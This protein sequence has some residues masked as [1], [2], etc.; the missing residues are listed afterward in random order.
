MIDRF[1]QLLKENVYSQR[2]L[3]NSVALVSTGANDYPFY[4]TAKKGSRDGLPAFT[5]GLVNQLA[6]DLQRINLL[7][8]KKVVA[9]TLPLLGCS[10]IHIIPPSTYQNCDE[11][12][13]KN[14]K[15]HNQLLQKAVEKLNTDDGN[16]STFV[17]LDLYN[18]M[19]SAIDQFRQNAAN[20]ACKNPLQP[21]CSKTVEY[22]CQRKDY[23]RVPSHLSFL[24]WH[25]L[26]TM[27][28]GM[29]FIHFCKVLLTKI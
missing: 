16:K 28:P 13:N 1:E 20:T 3:D 23:A 14:A 18:A 15:I 9:A 29:L 19:V 2:D 7:G 26:R 6:A 22:I 4:F 5:E 21:W 10:P 25:T 27:A 24:I 12:Y 8:M 17:I 11:E